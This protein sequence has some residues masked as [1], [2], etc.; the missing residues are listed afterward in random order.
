MLSLYKLE[1]FNT[2]AMEGSFSSAAGR[3][4]MTQPGVSQ[5]MRDLEEGL[6][7]KL[8][9][10]G[11]RGVSLTPAGE[12]LLDYTRCILRLL[13]DAEAALAN[14]EQ[15]EQG[16]LTIGAT[17]G[18]SVH[19]LP[20]WIQAFH[21]RFPTLSVLLR[22]DTTAA[23]A[24]ELLSGKL[25]LGFVEGELQV[26]PPLN[27]MALRDIELFVVVGRDHAWSERQ[28]ITLRSLADQPFIARPPGSQTR[29]W[30]NQVFDQFGLTP[31]IIAEF[32]NP[33]AIQQAV[34]SGMGVT[35]LP[36][37]GLDAD[38]WQGRLFPITLEDVALKR[39][40]K[41][42]WTDTPSLK[43]AERAFLT[44]LS[45]LFPQLTTIAGAT[46][47]IPTLLPQRHEYRAS[48]I[49]CAEPSRREG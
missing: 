4:H 31:R 30:V 46:D 8:F 38:R 44:L 13:A 6:G 20:Q 21:Q 43:P 33:E 29:T 12:T 1:I 14:L 22:T 34:A 9:E 5:H 23:I 2:V 28:K 24:N 45:D 3:L 41:L 37:W 19:L 35:I 11:P 42:L 10:R 48:G 36:E 25:D 18:A 39:T 40:L 32:D 7:R 16:Q 49:Y 26:D 27:A 17:P 15:L 47:L